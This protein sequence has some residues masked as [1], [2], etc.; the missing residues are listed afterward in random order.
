VRELG[1]A[2]AVIG[3][4]AKSAVSFYKKCV[5][6]IMINEK[7]SGVYKRMIDIDE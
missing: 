7:S 4:P 2:Y 1:Y 3:R 5:D 6:A